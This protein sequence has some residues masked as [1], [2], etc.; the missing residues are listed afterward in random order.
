MAGYI[1]LGEV[2]T[3]NFNI[4]YADPPWAYTF[5]GTRIKRKADYLT[6]NTWE[7]GRL[8]IEKL[9]ADDCTLF[10]WGTWPKIPDALEVMRAWGFEYKTVGFLWVKAN[11]TENTGQMCFI[12]QTKLNDFMGM[13]MWTRSNTEFCL[14]GVRGKP[15]RQSASVKQVVYSPL[16]RHS[17]KPG[18]VRDLIVELMGDIPR[19]ELFARKKT[20]GWAAW[21]NEIES[22]I[23]FG[24][25]SPS[26]I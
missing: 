11:P 6:M 14:I 5:P 17:E 7:I 24:F 25:S 12:P 10:M 3:L 9:A 18:E 19:I 13:G 21:G 8:H 23:D 15:K 26:G 1:P 2:L 20:A 22:D 16:L 4:I